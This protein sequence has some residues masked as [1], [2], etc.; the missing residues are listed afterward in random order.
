LTSDRELW[1]NCVK[2]NLKLELINNFLLDYDYMVD[3][4]SNEFSHVNIVIVILP[5]LCL[6]CFQILLEWCCVMWSI[7]FLT[8]SSLSLFKLQLLRFCNYLLNVKTILIMI[9]YHYYVYVMHVCMFLCMYVWYVWIMY[10][11]IKPVLKSL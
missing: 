3:W 1:T 2:S 10:I 9:F 8:L 4:A 5:R 7:V 11:Y 6:L